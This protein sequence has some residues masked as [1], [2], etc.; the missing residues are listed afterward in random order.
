LINEYSALN[1]GG[2]QTVNSFSAP[3][4]FL[5][6][7]LN[8]LKILKLGKMTVAMSYTMMPAVLRISQ[9]T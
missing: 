6:G 9:H 7:H 1:G 4:I 5:L 2:S 8:F 3:Q